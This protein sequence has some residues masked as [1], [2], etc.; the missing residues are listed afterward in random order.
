MMEW[1]DYGFDHVSD[2]F[3]HITKQQKNILKIILKPGSMKNSKHYSINVKI[4]T[5]YSIMIRI[6]VVWSFWP[7]HDD[8]HV[9]MMILLSYNLLMR[10][11]NGHVWLTDWWGGFE[12][13]ATM[14]MFLALMH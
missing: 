1:Y 3:P 6:D 2:Y 7:S 5:T 4:S 9:S 12:P 10:Y 13:N 14:I 11:F 8:D